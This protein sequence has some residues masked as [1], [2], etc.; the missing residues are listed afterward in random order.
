MLNISVFV[1]QTLQ[2]FVL[3]TYECLILCTFPCSI[4][5]REENV[6]TS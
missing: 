3:T 1:K 4:K 5:V 6:K 2:P